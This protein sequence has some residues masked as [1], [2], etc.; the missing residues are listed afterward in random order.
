M[1]LL[2]NITKYIRLLF[3]SPVGILQ[4]GLKVLKGCCFSVKSYNVVLYRIEKLIYR[5]PQ[6]H[7]VQFFSN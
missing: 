5:D 3:V 6:G 4:M 1:S 2:S 7:M